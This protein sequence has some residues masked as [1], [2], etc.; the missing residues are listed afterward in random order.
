MS[1]EEPNAS[2]EVDWVDRII[3]AHLH[4]S[5]PVS[6]GQSAKDICQIV[7]EENC[8]KNQQLHGN[9]YDHHN[10]KHRGFFFQRIQVFVDKPLQTIVDG[11]HYNHQSYDDMKVKFYRSIIILL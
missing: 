1:I 9:T 7:G 10:A 4:S 6:D 11:Y 2:Q 8:W 3:Q 5:E